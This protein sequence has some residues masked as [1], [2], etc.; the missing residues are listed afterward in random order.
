MTLPGGIR[1]KL[2]RLP[3]EIGN[4]PLGVTREAPGVGQHTREL[5]VELGLGEADIAKLESD[6]IVA[7]AK[8]A[9]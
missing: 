7:A 9:S 3:I 6:G 1:T 4:H 2:P 5:L 8:G